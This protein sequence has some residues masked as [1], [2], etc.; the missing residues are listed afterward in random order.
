M[1]AMSLVKLCKGKN[2]ILSSEASQQIYQRSP[3]DALTIANMLGV[4][5]T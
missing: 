5:N 2:L 3:T 1:N 4:S